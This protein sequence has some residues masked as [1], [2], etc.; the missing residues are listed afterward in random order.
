MKKH[1]QYDQRSQILAR[2]IAERFDK[3]PDLID[4]LRRW[5]QEQDDD[6]KAWEKVLEEDW[7]MFKAQVE[8]EPRGSL[9]QLL[10]AAQEARS[11]ET[12]ETEV[13]D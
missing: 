4:N 10:E 11:E 5:V 2:V 13:S 3:D 1:Q 9:Q 7:P 6:V 8:K 12:D